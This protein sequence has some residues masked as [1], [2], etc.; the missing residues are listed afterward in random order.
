MSDDG[1]PSADDIE[2]LAKLETSV[3]GGPGGKSA[4]DLAKAV[5]ER[6]AVSA[7]MTIS[8]LALHAVNENTKLRAAQYVTDRVMGPLTAANSTPPGEDALMDALNEFNDAVKQSD[9]GTS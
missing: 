1:Y 7:A 4:K 6:N 2:G 9:R 5:F 3:F 8:N